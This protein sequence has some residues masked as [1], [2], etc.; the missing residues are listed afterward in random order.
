ME[1][2]SLTEFSSSQL[3]ML[4]KCLPYFSRNLCKDWK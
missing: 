2:L 1:H 3:K 4:G